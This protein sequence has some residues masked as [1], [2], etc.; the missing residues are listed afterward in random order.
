MAGVT[1]VDKYAFDR[2]L[3][4]AAATDDEHDRTANIFGERCVSSSFG[5]P[6]RRKSPKI[7]LHTF[8]SISDYDVGEYS[9][10]VAGRNVH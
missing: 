10:L 7:V 5:T 8:L 1:I 2:R 4:A 3:K 6:I 9:F